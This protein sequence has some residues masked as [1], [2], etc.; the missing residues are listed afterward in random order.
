MKI[1]FLSPYNA[2]IQI[3]DSTKCN[4]V[5]SASG[6]AQIETDCL[7]DIV[8]QIY[9]AWGDT[10]MVTETVIEYPAPTVTPTTQDVINANIMARLATLEGIS[11][12]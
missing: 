5:N 1:L 4:Y 12:V 9:A 11:N 3:D 8:Q 2:S 6:R 7:T 10:P